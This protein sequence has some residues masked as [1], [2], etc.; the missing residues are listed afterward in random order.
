MTEQ[1]LGARVKH[2]LIILVSVFCLLTM[3]LWYLQVVKGEEYVRLADD[4]RIRPIPIRAP[5]G[6]IYDRSGRVIAGNR[7]SYTVSIVPK[8]LPEEKKPEVLAALA[9]LLDSSVEEI[10]KTLAAGAAYPYNPVR[11]KRD[12]PMEV[13]IAVEEERAD[14]PGML[15]EE[16]WT[17]Q[18]PYGDLASQTL[19]YLGL[20][21]PEDVRK[22]YKPTDYIGKTGLEKTYEAYLKGQDGQRRVE[23]NALSRPIRELSAIDPEPGYDLYLTI[24]LDLQLAAEKALTE[25]INRLQKLNYKQVSGG[26]V[27]VLAAKT[28]EVL[29]LCSQ[30]GYDLS[31][32]HSE[33]RNRYFTELNNN[34][35]KP[36]IH[37]ALNEYPPGSTFKVI[38]ALTALQSGALRVD[39]VYNATGYGKYGKKDWTLRSSPPQSPAGKVTVVGALAR[40]AND[41]F[42]EMALRPATGGVEALARTARNFGLGQPTGLE[43][44]PGEK[45]GLVPDREWKNKNYREVWYEAETMDMAI[46]QGYLLVTPLQLASVYMAVANMGLVY[47]PQLVQKIVSP[48]GQVVAQ[49]APE[50]TRH[51]K[52]DPEY[53]QVITEGLIAVTQWSN[54]TAAGSFKNAAYNPAGKT[55]SAQV[56]GQAAHAWFAGFAPADQPEIVVVVFVEHGESGSIAPAAAARS[57]MDAYFLRQDGQ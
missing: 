16:E 12:V 13:V 32:L 6:T 53:W 28:G 46:G 54:G 39:E 29:A 26:A 44:F 36:F 1:T 21:E 10:E 50:E 24:D 52:A 8:D 2:L 56:S 37:R 43:L 11:L 3:R 33:E 7:P 41:F 5:R 19:G 20:V 34:K 49:F 17:R 57:I 22:G 31:R 30:P 51:I 45:S 25:Q 40:S 47:R 14:L 4:N 48:A 35:N 23:V 18:Y 27:V 9:R 15:V 42:W 38:T 55:G